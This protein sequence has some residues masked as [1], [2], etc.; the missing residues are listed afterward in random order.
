MTVYHHIR[1]GLNHAPLHIE[2]RLIRELITFRVLNFWTKHVDFKKVVD[3]AW[4]EGISMGNPFNVVYSKMKRIKKTVAQWI[5]RVFG[6]II[7]KVATLEDVI[8]MAKIEWRYPFV[9]NRKHLIRQR[10]N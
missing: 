2:R 3:K 1:Q 10:Q 8:K 9:K 6:D 5:R 7:Y 4:N